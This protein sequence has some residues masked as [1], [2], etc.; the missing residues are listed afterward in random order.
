[1]TSRLDHEFAAAHNVKAA[2][3]AAGAAAELRCWAPTLWFYTAVQLIEAALADHGE[4]AGE[5]GDRIAMLA[6]P[7]GANTASYRKLQI[8]STRWRYH[9]LEPT[10]AEIESA[11]RWARDVCDAIHERWPS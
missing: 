10:T 1:M 4:H 8:L 5:H 2:R 9:A 3:A 11:E 7:L 6:A